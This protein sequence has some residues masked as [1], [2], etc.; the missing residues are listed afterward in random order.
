MY[1]L[2]PTAQN[3]ILAGNAPPD[4]RTMRGCLQCVDVAA[5]AAELGRVRIEAGA[6]RKS[7]YFRGKD[8]GVLRRRSPFP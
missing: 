4:L 7:Y 6:A 1:T 2:F 5:S 3:F 8:H